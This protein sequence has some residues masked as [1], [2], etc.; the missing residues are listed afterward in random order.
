MRVTSLLNSGVD[1]ET[2]H[3]ELCYTPTMVVC[4]RNEASTVTMVVN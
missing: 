3:P 1:V 4:A 2:R